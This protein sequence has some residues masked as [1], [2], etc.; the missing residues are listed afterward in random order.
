MKYFVLLISLLSFVQM[1]G[2]SHMTYVSP[3][4]K[5]EPFFQKV[6]VLSDMGM[7]NDF[8]IF[9]DEKSYTLNPKMNV[10]VEIECTRAYFQLGFNFAEEA[11]E[12]KLGTFLFGEKLV[13]YLAFSKQIKSFE[14]NPEG[15]FVGGFEANFDFLSM[16]NKEADEHSKFGLLISPFIEIGTSSPNE[17]NWFNFGFV[18]KPKYHIFVRS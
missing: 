16:F 15:L 17:E 2:Q 8:G 18:L 9:S 1:K 14:E 4:N 10:G 3:K 7:S 11:P 5:V 12:F 6:S 13:M